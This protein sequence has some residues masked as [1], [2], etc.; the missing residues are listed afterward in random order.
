MNIKTF[1]S[2]IDWESQEKPLKI[3]I[4]APPEVQ[5]DL[6]VVNYQQ[7][8]PFH[9]AAYGHWKVKNFSAEGQNEIQITVDCT[10]CTPIIEN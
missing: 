4:S 9:V 5:D 2:M 8:N 10:P 3:S 1:V 6:L 7:S